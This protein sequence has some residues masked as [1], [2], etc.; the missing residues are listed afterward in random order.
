MLA[1]ASGSLKIGHTKSQGLFAYDGTNFF[2][3]L[4]PYLIQKYL[5]HRN[6]IPLFLCGEWIVIGSYIT[7]FKHNRKVANKY[8]GYGECY[9]RK[10]IKMNG[11]GNDKETG[12]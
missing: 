5:K 9:S 12:N 7:A 3:V 6:K 11:G 10:D 1:I 4:S 2:K 8:I